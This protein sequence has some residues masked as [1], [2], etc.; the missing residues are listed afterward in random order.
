MVSTDSLARLGGRGRAS[1]TFSV[2]LHESTCKKS[3]TELEYDT[4]G[5]A[6]PRKE[7][8]TQQAR[9]SNSQ[10]VYP[11]TLDLGRVARETDVRQGV[12]RKIDDTCARKG[13]KGKTSETGFLR[14]R[15]RGIK[16]LLEER[17]V[18]QKQKAAKVLQKVHKLKIWKGGHKKEAEFFK[19]KR[20]NSEVEALRAGMLVG[21]EV[22]D[23]LREREFD[24]RSADSKNT[25]LRQSNS[26]E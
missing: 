12:K 8:K 19:G 15:N 24:K 20:A 2:V 6:W 26:A 14:I 18:E 5:L 7:T 13:K 9:D 21:E 25:K 23:D 3:N 17:S 4:R 10:I 1:L 22:D 16:K 11:N